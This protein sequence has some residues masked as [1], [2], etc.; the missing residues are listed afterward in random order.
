MN[1]AE[2][3]KVLEARLGSRKAA[4]DALESVVDSIIKEV[5]GS[6][7]PLARAATRTPV[8]RSRSPSP[9]PPGS[10]PARHSRP[11]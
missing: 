5:T 8:T 1:K 2:L 7:E 4:Q 11:S 10:A 9:R 3:V 6:T